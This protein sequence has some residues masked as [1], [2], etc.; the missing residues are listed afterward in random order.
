MNAGSSSTNGRSAIEARAKIASGAGSGVFHGYLGI[1]DEARL[2]E[3]DLRSGE[4]Q[5]P[6]HAQ[7]AP[8]VVLDHAEDHEIR[9]PRDDRRGGSAAPPDRRP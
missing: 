7:R 5:E 1:R 4:A 6:V 2:R 9:V 3:W 8:E